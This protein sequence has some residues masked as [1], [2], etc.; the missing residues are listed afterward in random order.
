MQENVELVQRGFRCLV[1]SLSGF[2]GQELSRKY[3]NSWWD[4]VLR[5]LNDQYDLP[6]KGSYGDLVDAL[7]VA[8]CIRL[9]D[10]RWGEDFRDLLSPN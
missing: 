7:D 5:S 1:R 6:W 3:K 10:R 9:I 8:N 4:E 2:I